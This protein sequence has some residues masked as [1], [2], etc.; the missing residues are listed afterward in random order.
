MPPAIAA[1]AKTDGWQM[2]EGASETNSKTRHTARADNNTQQ[3]PAGR[4]TQRPPSPETITACGKQPKQ[5]SGIAAKGGTAQERGSWLGPSS[6][7]ATV[8]P[9]YKSQSAAQQ[10]RTGAETAKPPPSTAEG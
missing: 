7:L 10:R 5:Q 2:E 1:A 3:Q 4:T 8:F 9:A 6:P